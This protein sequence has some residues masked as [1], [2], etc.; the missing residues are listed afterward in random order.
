MLRREF[1]CAI[2]AKSKTVR[3]AYFRDEYDLF[4]PSR[5][6][7]ALRIANLHF[8]ET[9]RVIKWISTRTIEYIF[10]CFTSGHRELCCENWPKIINR[11][12]AVY[13]AIT[14]EEILNDRVLKA[15][16]VGFFVE[17]MFDCDDTISDF[18]IGAMDSIQAKKTNLKPYKLF[19]QVLANLE[20]IRIAARFYNCLP[21]VMK[22]EVN[23]WPAMEA[24]AARFRH[25]NKNFQTQPSLKLGD[26]FG[27]YWINAIEMKKKRRN[28]G[29]IKSQE[30]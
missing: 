22:A 4:V 29:G 1:Y 17:L 13:H 20:G 8:S 26:C 12:N 24:I 21:D 14:K 2:S 7:L 9:D 3:A 15:S 18:V 23:P 11:F 16:S 10:T 19:M 5:I 6:K 25:D 28:E 27:K 30:E